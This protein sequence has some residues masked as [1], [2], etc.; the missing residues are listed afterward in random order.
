MK[1]EEQD[2]YRDVYVMD[3]L[4]VWELGIRLTNGDPYLTCITDIDSSSKDAIKYLYHQVLNRDLTAHIA[5]NPICQELEDYAGQQ[6]ET[7]IAIAEIDNA[8]VDNNF[9]VDVLRSIM[10]SKQS[11]FR[12]CLETDRTFPEF[13]GSVDQ[14]DAGIVWGDTDND[15]TGQIYLS[16]KWSEQLKMR[17][18]QRRRIACSVVAEHLWNIDE[19]IEIHEMADR[20]EL[21]EL[22]DSGSYQHDTR[23]NWIKAYA[24]EHLHKPGRRPKK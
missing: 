19:T 11:F 4:N 13:W 12:W 3:S 14:F 7:F 1:N 9:E 5:E 18:S 17:P 15:G 22:C 16:N 8:I 10:V 2:Q 24:P 20:Q 21:L 23:H 6:I